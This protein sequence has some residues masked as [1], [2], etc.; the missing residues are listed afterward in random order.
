MLFGDSITEESFGEGGWGAYLANHY[1]RSADVILRG[2]SGYNTRWAARVLARAVTGI[3]SASV[4]AVTVLFGANDASLP[5]RAS[6]FQYVP[7]GEYRENLRAIC[8]LLRDRWPAAAVILVTPPPVDE[9]GR[10]RFIGGGGGDG[11]GLPERTNQATGEYARACVQV[12][13]ECGLRVIDIWSRMQM[14]PGWETSFLRDGLHLTPRGNRLLFEEV[15]W[16]LG[17]AN[18]S[19]E[20]LP[21]DLPLCSDIDPDNAAKYFE[22]EEEEE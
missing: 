12:A 18:L 14:F 22:E 1:S 13:V 21:A 17:D 20:A 4:A 5:T 19:L 9:R 7:L 6:A 8:A 10:L 3:P 11:S 16:A 15:V 2:Y